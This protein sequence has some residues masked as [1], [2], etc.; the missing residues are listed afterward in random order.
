MGRVKAAGLDVVLDADD[1]LQD[2]LDL[3]VRHLDARRTRSLVVAI[4]V[5]NPFLSEQREEG[6]FRLTHRALKISSIV[7]LFKFG[8]VHKLTLF[9]RWPPR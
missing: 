5:L 9:R 3:V 7:D 8:V 6:L 4:A 2:A 1:A